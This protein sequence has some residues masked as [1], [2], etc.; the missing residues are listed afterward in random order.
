MTR[1]TIPERLDPV[2]ELTPFPRVARE[3]HGQRPR[4]RRILPA[5]LLA[6]AT[7]GMAI[8]IIL[9]D[10]FA[11]GAPIIVMLGFIGLSLLQVSGPLRQP[12]ID[13]PLDEREVRDHDRS[14]MAGLAVMAF[15]TI[16]F[17]CLASLGNL[18][19][20]IWRPSTPDDWRAIAFFLI[21]TV[22]GTRM[23]YASWVMPRS[24][25]DEDA[26]A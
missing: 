5:L 16:G 18:F 21:A 3:G 14:N 20:D 12:S 15:I 8:Q 13:R 22:I 2:A 19:P 23:L 10:A 6:V 24:S 11:I 7:F 4:P 9:P 25:R 17:A 1:K 26:L